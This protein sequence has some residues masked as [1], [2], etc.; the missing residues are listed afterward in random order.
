MTDLTNLATSSFDALIANIDDNINNSACLKCQ[1]HNNLL[2][3]LDCGHNICI[4]CT[5]SIISNNINVSTCPSCY[6]PLAQDMTQ[7][8]AKCM[9]DPVMK[10]SFYH[11]IN[12]GDTLWYYSG[13]NRNWLYSKDHCDQ[14]TKVYDLYT[15]TNSD[16]YS[17]VQ[18]QIATPVLETYIID[19]EFD[20]Q[21]NIKFP[22][23]QRNIYHF[24]YNSGDDLKTHKII[25]VAGTFL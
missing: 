20:V 4:N 11:K 5:N 9:S 23:K 6:A 1:L 2:I 25:G 13:N 3:E 10:L 19:F 14:I 8:L 17:T 22:N 18:I 7:L 16:T 12:I 15:K 24:T 21:Y